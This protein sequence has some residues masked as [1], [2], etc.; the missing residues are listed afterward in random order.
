[1]AQQRPSTIELDRLM[2]ANKGQIVELRQQG[3]TLNDIIAWLND[4]G[5]PIKIR[6]LSEYL[7]GWNAQIQRKAL[8]DEQVESAILPLARHTLLSDAQ[9]ASRAAGSHR[10]DA[11][12]EQVGNARIRHRIM[13][14]IDDPT[15][16]NAH[17]LET[18]AQVDALLRRGGG[19]LH[20]RRWAITHLRH[21]F[22][23]HAHQVDVSLAMNQVD[24]RGV[25]ERR[26]AR[27]WRRDDFVTSGPD[28][29]WS[30]DGHDKLLRWGI[31]IYGAID[32]YS[33]KII[34]WYVGNSNKTQISVVRQYLRAI[35]RYG[36]V[37]NYI[38]T[39]AGTECAMLADC[40]FAFYLLHGLIVE[41][42][43][44]EK[45]LTA[46]LNDCYIQ[47][48]S[49]RN[50]RIERTW[51]TQGHTTT[52]VWIDYFNQLERPDLMLFNEGIPVDK[53]SI[54]FL[55]MPLIREHLT[56]FV[57]THNAHRIRKQNRRYHVPGV[58]DELYDNDRLRSG[59][60]ANADLHQMWS[61]EVEF[62][63][64]DAYLTD[65]TMAWY[66]AQMVDLQH[67]QAPIMSEFI[68]VG[69]N[70]VPEWMGVLI[71]RARDHVMSRVEPFLSLAPRP[72]GG[73]NEELLNLI[74][75]GS[76]EA[77]LTQIYE[78]LDNLMDPE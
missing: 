57:A 8:S 17:R 29:L 68:G 11:S 78:A 54:C 48:S 45:L 26:L 71:N 75:A 67:P 25:L 5:V 20:G 69:E 63:D 10:I 9:I 23:H 64:F 37:P 50:I 32:A 47:A 51:N 18:V 65:D 76:V 53:V 7:Q 42:W 33:R 4:A 52:R 31:Q 16:R 46:R 2:E 35:E 34:W 41:G 19:L 12:A 70:I 77:D 62:Y 27:T 74:K 1:M 14:R 6:K 60:P 28:W 40:H 22:G 49:T 39:D 72:E 13:R 44:D 38:R 66:Q 15:E 30:L 58:P 55:F 36:R 73:Y 61:S 24:P 59:I 43:P 56:D 21:H 3:I